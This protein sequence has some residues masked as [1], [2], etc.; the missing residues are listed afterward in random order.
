[1][2]GELPNHSWQLSGQKAAYF[3]RIKVLTLQR[4]NEG[5]YGTSAG[6]F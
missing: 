4:C 5:G 1:M 2:I 6:R 3:L